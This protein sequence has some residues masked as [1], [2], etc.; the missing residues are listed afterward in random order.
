MSIRIQKLNNTA[1]SIGIRKRGVF[2]LLRSYSEC[3]K[4]NLNMEI[5]LMLVILLKYQFILEAHDV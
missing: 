1:L 5:N 2:F 3:I 4:S